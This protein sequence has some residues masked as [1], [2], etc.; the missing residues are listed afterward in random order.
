MNPED[1]TLY[2]Q[3]FATGI[4]VLDAFDVQHA[5][6]SLPEIA[7]AAGI[8][9]SAAQR[10]A[11]TLEAIGLLMKD[12]VSKRYSLS[13]R[14]LDAGCRYLQSHPLLDRA[15]P[16]LLELNRSAGETVNL[17]E[18]AGTDM[19]Y[20]GRFPSPMRL[21][22]HMPIGRRIPM[23]CSSAGR[24]FLSCLPEEQARRVLQ[25][26]QPVRFTPSTVVDVDELLKRLQR[27]RQDG[28]AYCNGEYYRGD[29][30]L[31][32]PV[33]DLGQRVVASLQVSVSASRWSLD[34]AVS[35]FVPMMQETAR[36]ISTTPP[37][38]R[39]L[40]SLLGPHVD[41]PATLGDRAGSR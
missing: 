8:S 32:V 5:S 18:P 41:Q 4:A 26:T 12:P 27:A 36:L 20:I 6:M 22:V 15:N 37:T 14:T 1:S 9:R 24:A 40:A 3:S 31:A 16:Y 17:A 11:F 10:F 35:R 29:L 38:Q 19:I 34:R 39:A 30:A 23:Y 2:V 25:S 13:S 33:F 21:M 28:Y 7:A